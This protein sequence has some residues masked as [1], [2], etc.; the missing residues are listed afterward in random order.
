MSK[1]KLEEGCGMAYVF[2]W[3]TSWWPQRVDLSPLGK[4]S[5]RKISARW[6]EKQVEKEEMEGAGVWHKEPAYG[7]GTGLNQADRGE[8]DEVGMGLWLLGVC[9]V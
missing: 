1:D 9:G 6:A 3:D 2:I 4:P 8:S 7:L 5:P